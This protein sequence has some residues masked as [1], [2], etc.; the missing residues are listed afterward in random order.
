MLSW[1]GAKDS[2]FDA[3]SREGN[4][5]GLRYETVAYWAAALD[6][7]VILVSSL[8][9]GVAYNEIVFGT[10][11]SMAGLTAVGIMVGAPFVACL[12]AFGRYRPSELMLLKSQML[13]TAAVISACFTFLATTLFLLKVGEDISRGAIACFAATSITAVLLSRV[14]WAEQLRWAIKYGRFS[15]KR[16]LLICPRDTDVARFCDEISGYG[17]SVREILHFE[18]LVTHSVDGQEPVPAFLK[19]LTV[20]EVII[21]ASGAKP[22]NIGAVLSAIRPVPL[23]KKVLF[24]DYLNEILAK[25]ARHIGER[26][27]FQV[28]KQ[29]LSF[30]ERVMKRTLDIVVAATALVTLLPILAIVSIAI[31]LDSKGP[32]LFVQRRRG[33]G[34]APFAILKFRSMT[35]LEDSDHVVQASR[36]DSRVTRV[37]KVIRAT[38]IDELPQF[39]NVLRG[40]MSLVGPRPHALAH[41][42]RYDQLLERYPLRR[43]VKPGLT[44]WAQINGLRGETSTVDRMEMRIEYDLWYI[45]NWTIW[46][47]LKIILKT[48]PLFLGHNSAY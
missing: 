41:D 48:M 40:D 15:P 34:D 30:P 4:L 18:R 16:V 11:P 35:V 28:Q 33:Y 38:S 14:V 39:W 9:G 19:Y 45:H 47:D 13:V 20:D 36:F 1:K 46:L 25:P 8:F 2:A 5:V 29:S 7:V 42:A 24:D 32:I 21:Y 31:K 17:F 23:P 22:D 37:G 26:V 10:V 12:A 3:V 27:A 6:F 44:G 43:H